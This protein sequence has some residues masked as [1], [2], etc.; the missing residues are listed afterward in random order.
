M[1]PLPPAPRRLVLVQKRLLL[2]LA[3]GCERRGRREEEEERQKD[4]YERQIKGEQRRLT[5]CDWIQLTDVSR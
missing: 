5:V 3:P 4:K 1:Q 2:I